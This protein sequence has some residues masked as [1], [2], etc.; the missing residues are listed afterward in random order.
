MQE[1]GQQTAVQ[2]A[3]LLM[4]HGAKVSGLI[5]FRPQ[6]TQAAAEAVSHLAKRLGAPSRRPNYGDR[7]VDRRL[8]ATLAH[9]GP[10][11]RIYSDGTRI[12]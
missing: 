2:A 5:T 11:G 1:V 10:P 6:T 9:N 8:L 3:E 4:E 7:G 12:R